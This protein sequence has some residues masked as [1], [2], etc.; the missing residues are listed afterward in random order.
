MIEQA[1]FTY[2]HLRT[3]LEKPTKT[4]ESQGEKQIKAIEEYGKQL[5]KSSGFADK[6][7]LLLDKQKEIFY[8]LVAERMERIENS[9]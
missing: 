2:S 9:Q 3:A 4:I 7:S 5:V 8:K 1:K 6:D